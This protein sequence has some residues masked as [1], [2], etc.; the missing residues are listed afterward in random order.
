MLVVVVVVVLLLRLIPLRN[1]AVTGMRVPRDR[2]CDYDGGGYRI[3][4]R[5]EV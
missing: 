5:R 4:E 3:Y 1:W 2:D